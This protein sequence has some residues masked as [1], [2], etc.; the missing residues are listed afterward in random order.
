MK[1]LVFVFAFALMATVSM[2]QTSTPQKIGYA[3]V[4]YI[5]SQM[6]EAKKIETELQTMQTQLKKQ[7]DAQVANFQK[8]L[9]EYQELGPTVIDAVRQNSEREL[10]Q[11]QQNIQKFEQ[12]SQADLEKK[13]NSLLGP[14]QE[15]VGK[16][17]EETAKENGFS[18]ILNL[19]LSGLDV[20]L[21]GD[22][23]FDVSDLVLKKMGITPAPQQQ[24]PAPATNNTTTPTKKP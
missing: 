10:Q 5:F 22:E 2:A 20:V 24:Q 8:K 14:V 3:D 16:S 12:D 21:Y 19:Q 18:L 7:Y 9:K 6:P 17:I 13:R 15:K 23:K 11:I 4:E 1:K